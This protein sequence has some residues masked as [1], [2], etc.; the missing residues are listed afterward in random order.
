MAKEKTRGEELSAV[1]KQTMARAYSAMDYYFD[2]LKKTVAL[3]PIG[4]TEFGERVKACA[5]QN[6]CATQEYVRGLLT[7]RISKIYF[8]FRWSSCGR[9]WRRLASR[10]TASARRTSKQYPVK[11]ESCPRRINE[12]S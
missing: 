3:A 12:P 5:E 1:S 10:L 2:Y 11:R 7:P 6:I 8:E 9:N 4:G